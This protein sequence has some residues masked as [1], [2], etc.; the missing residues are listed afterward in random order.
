M[1]RVPYGYDCTTGVRA[2]VRTNLALY[3]YVGN[4]DARQLAD[5]AGS[6]MAC[7]EYDPNGGPSPWRRGR[8]LPF[9]FS[10]KY[11]DDETGLVYCGL[12]YYSPTFG[13]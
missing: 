5:A 6:L 11:T 8:R 10:T 1:G 4:G 2:M 7:Y 3:C 13:W 9:R 12:V